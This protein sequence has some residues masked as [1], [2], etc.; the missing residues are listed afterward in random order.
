MNLLK[1]KITRPDIQSNYFSKVMTMIALLPQSARALLLGTDLCTS[2]ACIM[3]LLRNQ[4]CL[5]L[6]SST[7]VSVTTNK[8]EKIFLHPRCVQVVQI[9][10]SHISS[11][12][13]TL[14]CLLILLS[15]NSVQWRKLFFHIVW[16][17]NVF[18]EKF[19]KPP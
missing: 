16:Q 13:S 18:A 8:D 10:R 3:H 6:N 5:F 11:C 7:L 17:C 9:Q 2:S 15:T 14:F 19:N 1:R 12:A 4:L